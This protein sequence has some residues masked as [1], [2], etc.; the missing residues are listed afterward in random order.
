MIGSVSS[1]FSADVKMH[2]S[3]YSFETIAVAVFVCFI[4]LCFFWLMLRIL[5][6]VD[7]VVDLRRT[8]VT[9]NLINVTRNH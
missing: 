3:L 4:L 1:F 9:C 6:L 5:S 2:R 7:N 8:E